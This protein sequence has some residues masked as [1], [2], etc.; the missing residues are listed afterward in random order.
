MKHFG[1]YKIINRYLRGIEGD[2]NENY[3]NKRPNIKTLILIQETG[4]CAKTWSKDFLLAVYERF[5]KTVS[6]SV[7]VQ[8]CTGRI[9]GY[10]NNPNTVAF[11]KLDSIRRY[12][13]LFAHNYDI[14]RAEYHTGLKVDDTMNSSKHYTNLDTVPE[15]EPVPD[16]LSDSSDFVARVIN[17]N[18][19]SDN[20]PIANKI[21]DVLTRNKN[22]WEDFT[23]EQFQDVYEEFST[24][25]RIQKFLFNRERQITGLLTEVQIET[26]P[27]LK[28]RRRN[29]IYQ[30]RLD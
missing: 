9:C 10:D 16:T 2:I 13:T 18:N 12:I 23:K 1:N 19:L 26:T 7:I 24:G 15:P 28:V 20:V 14:E 22:S 8:G 21:R 27:G 11:C 3:L 17:I 5:T 6:D 29:G 30:V 25:D 4:R